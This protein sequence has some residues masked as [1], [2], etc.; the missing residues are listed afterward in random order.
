MMTTQAAETIRFDQSLEVFAATVATTL[1]AKALAAGQVLRDASGRLA[2]ISDTNLPEASI[3]AATEALAA[4]L[5]TYCRTGR[6]LLTPDHPGVSS[7]LSC[8]RGYLE[9]LETPLGRVPVRVIEQRIVGQ[10][11][12]EAPSPSVLPPAPARVVFA[13]LKG[14]V[15]R[16]TALAVVA[17]DL[18][19][20]G[21]KVL[22]IDLD[23]EA[24]G[25]GAMMLT[26][27]AQPRF[28]L[29]D[30]YVERSLNGVNHAFLL[31]MVAPSDF[32]AGRGLI[33][34]APAIGATGRQYPANVLAKIARAYLDQPSDEDGTL[35]FLHQTRALVD[36]L[37]GLKHYDAI[38]IDARAGL[39]ETTAAAIL[40][41]GAQVLLFGE[42]TPQ[43][44]AGYRYLLAHL[45][46]FPRNEEDD[47]LYR[48]RMVHAKASADADKQQAFRDKAHSLFQ[49]YLYRDLPLPD[50]EGRP[51]PDTSLPE[52]SL[53]DPEAP[54]FAWPVFRDS[55]YFE[56]DPFA[57]PAQLTPARYARTYQTL[58][59]G[60]DAYLSSEG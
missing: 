2:F 60:I 13:S 43:T 17:A 35:S 34:V 32:G 25:I 12:L 54:H 26:S 47:W 33:E 9:A 49:E 14:G 23:L 16:S 36:D 6:I 29:L 46:R 19:R 28:G 51:S 45:A 18:A 37:A 41:L 22:V 5:P 39:N 58:T 50:E 10:D 44:F 40:G 31:D 42:N 3:R 38:L 4:R 21:K 7:V 53:D 20:R 59:E 15:G 57:E 30:W 24:P 11:W 1:G 8:G 52:V 48:L 55:N 56:F 27:E